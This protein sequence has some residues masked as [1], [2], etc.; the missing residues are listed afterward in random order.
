MFLQII[1]AQSSPALW[2]EIKKFTQVLIT[3]YSP[4]IQTI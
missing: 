1:K 4:V 2:L 3:K